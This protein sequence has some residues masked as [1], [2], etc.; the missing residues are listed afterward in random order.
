M[1]IGIIT[2]ISLIVAAIM[3]QEVTVNQKLAYDRFCRMN[4]YDES[5]DSTDGKVKCVNITMT[6]WL[7]YRG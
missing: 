2:L 3:V 1:L 4:G 7:N 6:E 5:V